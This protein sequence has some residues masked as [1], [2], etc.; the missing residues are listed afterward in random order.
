L[1][2]FLE[3]DETEVNGYAYAGVFTALITAKVFV[4]NWYFYQ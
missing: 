3:S 4:E 1:I 2:R